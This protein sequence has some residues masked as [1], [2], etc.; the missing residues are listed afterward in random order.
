MVNKFEKTFT[1]HFRLINMLLSVL[2]SPSSQEQTGMLFEIRFVNAPLTLNKFLSRAADFYNPS[3]NFRVKELF[4]SPWGNMRKGMGAKV[5]E[6]PAICTSVPPKISPFIQPPFPFVR[7]F[8]HCPFPTLHSSQN[9]NCCTLVWLFW[10]SLLRVFWEYLHLSVTWYTRNDKVTDDVALLG[11]YKYDC[12]M[13]LS[14]SD[15]QVLIQDLKI[16]CPWILKHSP[17][18]PDVNRNWK[19]VSVWIMPNQIP[20]RLICVNSD[21]FLLIFLQFF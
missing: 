19:Y 18:C 20:K 7:P 12:C 15:H 5:L 6:P 8:Q 17:I 9:M 16:L 10:L 3:C 1:I 11:G 13:F 4:S 21:Y 14:N 2:E